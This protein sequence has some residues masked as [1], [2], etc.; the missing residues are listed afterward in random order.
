MLKMS[1]LKL[2]LFCLDNGVHFNA[3]SNDYGY[4]SVVPGLISIPARD[5]LFLWDH[6]NPW[7]IDTGSLEVI[8]GK[9]SE[10][11][12][13]SFENSGER[14]EGF[15]DEKR[16]VVVVFDKSGEIIKYQPLPPFHLFEIKLDTGEVV[17]EIELSNE[18]TDVY[19][20]P[21]KDRIIFLNPER[22]RLETL[23]LYPLWGDPT[24]ITPSTN[25]V[26]VG[27]G[28]NCRFSVNIKNEYDYE[29]D[30]TAYIWLIAP[31]GTMLFFDGLGFTPD[32]TGIPLTLPANLDVNADFLTFTMPA[33]VPEGFY[34]LNALFINANGDRGPIGTWNFYVKG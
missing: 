29:Q 3:H 7:C 6:N 27:E 28:D 15:W 9:F 14:M 16:E 17:K 20:P 4:Y 24:T 23:H 19:F 8:Y 2:L 33:G 22:E 34:N 26:Q 13:W 5:R 1:T 32:I 10:N 18:Y 12:D 11:S 31:D 25:Y 21:E 30:A